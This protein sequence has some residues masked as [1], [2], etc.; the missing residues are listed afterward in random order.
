MPRYAAEDLKRFTQEV[1]RREGV[2]EENVGIIA[3]HL[4]RANLVGMD[5]HGLLRIPQYIE[6]IRSGTID[7][8][9]FYKI[10]HRGEFEVKREDGAVMLHWK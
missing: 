4:I 1:F 8:T 9:K 5:S 2:P 6:L 7:G 3:D 10:N